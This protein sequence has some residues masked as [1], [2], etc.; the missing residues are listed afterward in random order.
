MPSK[1]QLMRFLFLHPRYFYIFYTNPIK[2]GEIFFEKG[3][4]SEN[5]S[6]PA[7]S[8]IR[9][10]AVRMQHGDWYG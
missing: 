5:D 6:D 1:W 10:F 3:I 7:C 2:K 8:V 4:D 9:F